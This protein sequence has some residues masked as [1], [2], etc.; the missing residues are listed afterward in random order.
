MS[1]SL[2]QRRPHLRPKDIELSKKLQKA[3]SASSDIPEEKRVTTIWN[4]AIPHSAATSCP[5]DV[6]SRAA[7]ER[8]DKGFGVNNTGLAVFSISPTPSTVWARML[9]A[10]AARKTLHGAKRSPTFHPTDEPMMIYPAI[11]YKFMGGIW[12]RL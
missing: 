6:A 4:A 3:R 11:H 8:C 2:R 9:R 7:K 12:S 10:S 1:E 5:R